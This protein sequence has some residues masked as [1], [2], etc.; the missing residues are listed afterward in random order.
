MKLEPQQLELFDIEPPDLPLID[1]NDLVS[2]SDA[3]QT[4]V[5]FC[6]K[7]N[8]G[9]PFSYNRMREIL[10]AMKL[11]HTIATTYSKEDATD[12]Q[13]KLCEYKSTITDEINGTYNGISYYK[14]WDEQQKHTKEKIY[15]CSKHYFARFKDHINIDEL[16]EMSCEDVWK[17]LE[18][19]F[20]KSWE[21][22]PNRKD[23]RVGAQIKAAEIYQYGTK[24]PV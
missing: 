17:I 23:P 22:S 6:E 7:Y 11:K 20:K 9:D 4:I 24:I 18:P 2:F 8:L 14:T 10:M 13:N 15:S 19:K 1:K 16:Y 5:E 3:I 12:R 21:T